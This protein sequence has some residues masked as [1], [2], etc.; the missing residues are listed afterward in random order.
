MVFSHLPWYLLANISLQVQIPW[1]RWGKIEIYEILSKKNLHAINQSKKGF[2]YRVELY[3][4][5]KQ[6][7]NQFLYKPKI[8]KM[9]N[10]IIKI[11]LLHVLQIDTSFVDTVKSVEEFLHFKHTILIIF[12]DLYKISI[13]W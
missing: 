12:N 11:C 10:Y 13:E 8:F 7:F 1:C 5:Q 3:V 6:A 9:I 2:L 4:K